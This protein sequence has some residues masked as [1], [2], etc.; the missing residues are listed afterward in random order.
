[1]K[2]ALSG[3]TDLLRRLNELNS[4]VGKDGQLMSEAKAGKKEC[5]R[6]LADLQR[7]MQG[8]S[9]ELASLEGQYRSVA[10]EVSKGEKQAK[11][12]QAGIRMQIDSKRGLLMQKQQEA[13][14]K[15]EQISKYVNIIRQLRTN[16][17]LQSS[18]IENLKSEFEEMK[19]SY[20]LSSNAFTSILNTKYA[21]AAAATGASVTSDKV[22][23]C[24]KGA[25]YCNYLQEVINILLSSTD[26]SDDDGL[27]P[28]PS[29]NNPDREE[30]RSL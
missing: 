13:G 9:G 16:L 6:K 25:K 18:T 11:I 14:Q 22:D 20:Q 24:E 1:M 29:K 27:D 26:S 30:E 7:E 8:L 10:N 3:I 15:R 21:G 17:N 28:S 12:R 23:K 4:I 2:A 5:Q 19:G